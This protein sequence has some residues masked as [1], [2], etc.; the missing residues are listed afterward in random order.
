MLPVTKGSRIA[1]VY[2]LCWSEETDENKKPPVMPINGVMSIQ[3]LSKA[4]GQWLKSD[5]VANCSVY[6]SSKASSDF[7]FFL[8]TL[9]HRYTTNSLSRD[10]LSALKGGDAVIANALRVAN[11]SLPESERV[12]FR[13]VCVSRSIDYEEKDFGSGLERGAVKL[14]KFFS[15]NGKELNYPSMHLTNPST[16][17][18]YVDDSED[19]D[20]ESDEDFQEDPEK[21]PIM[22]KAGEIFGE[23]KEDHPDYTGNEYYST[24]FTYGTYALMICTSSFEEDLAG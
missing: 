1:V 7:K 2:S 11:A 15:A 12:S 16:I 20:S 24:S 23:P 4:L 5:A 18:G 21:H 9:S 10:G 14:S 22:V 3:P 13:I 17:V 6:Y 8:K 19:N